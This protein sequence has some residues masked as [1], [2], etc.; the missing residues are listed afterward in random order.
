MYLNIIKNT[1]NT[2]PYILDI[3]SIANI[4]IADAGSRNMLAAEI[5]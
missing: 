2:R 5:C 4:S 3:A 1:I